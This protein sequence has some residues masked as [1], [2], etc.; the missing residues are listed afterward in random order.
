MSHIP[1]SAIKERLSSVRESVTTLEARLA[2]ERTAAFK[3]WQAWGNS[4]GS[5]E[6]LVPAAETVAQCRAAESLTEGL[7]YRARGEAEWLENLLLA[8]DPTVERALRHGVSLV[9]WSI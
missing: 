3:S 9:E 5:V 6:S 8:T 1:K 7:L 2:T 4:L